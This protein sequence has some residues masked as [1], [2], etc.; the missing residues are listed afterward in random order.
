MRYNDTQHIMEHLKVVL[1]E[2]PVFNAT[3]QWKQRRV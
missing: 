1:E 2:I 3:L